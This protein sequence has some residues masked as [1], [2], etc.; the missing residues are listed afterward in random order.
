[1]RPFGGAQEG[2][3]SRSGTT[4]PDDETLVRGSCI[5]ISAGTLRWNLTVIVLP[6]WVGID[7][8]AVFRYR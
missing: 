3:G 4:M 8:C 7:L 5:A 1:M 6:V 2:L